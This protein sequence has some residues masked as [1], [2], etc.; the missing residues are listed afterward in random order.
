MF[1]YN[2]HK[3][4]RHLGM[5]TDKGRVQPAFSRIL[6]LAAGRLGLNVSS[7][8]RPTGHNTHV[9]CHSRRN[10][11]VTKSWEFFATGVFKIYGKE[12]CTWIRRADE[13]VEHVHRHLSL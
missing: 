11:F 6:R 8:K 4:R 1:Y 13:L 3:L 7:F 12:G 10:F 5:Q 2:M 9:L